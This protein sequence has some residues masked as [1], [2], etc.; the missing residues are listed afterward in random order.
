[1]LVFPITKVYK[2]S[3]IFPAQDEVDLTP[4]KWDD[5]RKGNFVNLPYQ[6]AH[7]TTRVAMDDE[8]NSIKLENLFEFVSKYRL[9][10]AEFKKLIKLNLESFSQSY[11]F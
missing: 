1:M 8:C 11:P 6:K 5:K 2:I 3:D 10:P 4:E 9:T 7:M